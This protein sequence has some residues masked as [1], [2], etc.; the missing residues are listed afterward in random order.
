MKQVSEAVV[1]IVVAAAAGLTSG[2]IL[3]RSRVPTT[4]HLPPNR[5]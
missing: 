2:L 1:V 3:S 4:H 5:Q